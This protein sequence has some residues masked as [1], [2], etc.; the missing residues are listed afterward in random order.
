MTLASLPCTHSCSPAFTSPLVRILLSRQHLGPPTHLDSEP[1]RTRQAQPTCSLRPP[2]PL[3]HLLARSP[4]CRSPVTPAICSTARIYKTNV[5]NRE[6]RLGL[7]KDH[8]SGSQQQ[9]AVVAPCSVVPPLDH[10]SLLMLQSANRHPP[11]CPE[12]R[13]ASNDIRLTSSAEKPP[14]HT[15]LP[16]PSITTFHEGRHMPSHTSLAP[17]Q[18]SPPPPPPLI[19]R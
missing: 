3:C 9:H 11:F 5:R 4:P 18:Q 17:I 6:G 8:M 13:G 16:P 2:F 12:S 1:I 19:P 15:T 14:S 10:G 7:R